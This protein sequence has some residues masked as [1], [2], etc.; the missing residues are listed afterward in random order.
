MKV[1]FGTQIQS[2]D[3]LIEMPI[4]SILDLIS[5]DITLIEKTNQLRKFLSLDETIYS[6]QKVKLPYFSGS[7]FE[8]GKRKTENFV[9]AES[10]IFDF[11]H[12]TEDQIQHSMKLLTSLPFIV[13]AY[14]SPSNCGIKLMVALKFPITALSGSHFKPT[15]IEIGSL[16]AQKLGLEKHFDKKT[17]DSTRVS[18]LCHDPLPYFNPKFQYYSNTFDSSQINFPNQANPLEETDL[19]K[20]IPVSK[21][22]TVENFDQIKSILGTSKKNS[23]PISKSVV[24]HEVWKLVECAEKDAHNIGI[25]IQKIK[26]LPYGLK[27]KGSFKNRFCMI[28]IFYGKKG[29]SFVN[30]PMHLADVELGEVTKE[31]L[32]H[33]IHEAE[34]TYQVNSHG[35]IR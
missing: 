13:L 11:D 19:E 25:Q 29:F 24:P 5:T 34:E 14:R 6:K 15:F 1:S 2:N 26:H 27:I 21:K 33:L 35:E 8:N 23:N 16:I 17:F 20:N 31:W 30:E 4:Q 3:S 12:L 10:M 22:K 18:F 32:E 28:N 7:F 9:C